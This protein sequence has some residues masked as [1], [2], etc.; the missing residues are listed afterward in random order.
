MTPTPIPVAAGPDAKVLILE[1]VLAIIRH[2]DGTQERHEAHNIVTTAG[3]VYY[4]QRA[5]TETPTNAFANL[6]LGST[7]SPTPVAGDDYSDI[8]AI[9][10]TNKAKASGYP[11][12]NDS[13]TDNTGAATNAISWKFSYA[14]AE[15]TAASVTEGV[16]T[17]ASPIAGSPVLCH[18]AFA[19]EFPIESTDALVVY[20]NHTANGA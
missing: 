20:V 2:E 16:I 13:D 18:F 11:K 19:A 7:V 8:T 5:C 15:F 1:N 12:S 4:A 17:I 10:G 14:A 6:V 3:A 9:A